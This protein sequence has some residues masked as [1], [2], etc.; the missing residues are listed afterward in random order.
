MIFVGY[1]SYA[2]VNVFFYTI[3]NAPPIKLTNVVCLYVCVCFFFLF[4]THLH[5]N[6]FKD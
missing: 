2:N 5:T 3:N 1:L 4:L 6:V